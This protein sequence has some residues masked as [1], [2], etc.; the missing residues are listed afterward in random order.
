MKVGIY[1]RWQR[2]DS[3][4]A[5][6]QIADLM[7]LWQ[8]EVTILT[9]TPKRPTVS[10]FWDSRVRQDS[11]IRFTDWAAQLAVVIWTFWPT[12]G[13]LEWTL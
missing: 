11:N 8:H 5:A 13:Q 10:N 2:R 1:T 7:S 9:P 6:I 12:P 3:T 4:Y